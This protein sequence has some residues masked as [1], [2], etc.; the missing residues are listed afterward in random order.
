MVEYETEEQELEA[1]KKWL[2]ENGPSLV[3]GLVLGV[4]GLFG[5]RYY[6]DYK[7]GHSA[8]ASDRYQSVLQQ[9]ATGNVD[10]FT[11]VQAEQLRK[12]YADTP[13]AVLA[14]LA[15]ARNEHDN[16]NDEQALS[17]LDW[18]MKN[19]ATPELEHTARLRTARILL[20]Q[21]KYDEAAVILEKDYPAGFTA[22][23]EELKGDLYIARGDASQARVAYDRAISA[24][25]SPSRWLR[26]KRQDLG[27][28][29][30]GGAEQNDAAAVEPPA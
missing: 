30:M 17:H 24:S 9:V 10:E 16:G 4:G 14:S 20:A 26:L 7:T 21:K 13:Y 28:P 11:A 29:E 15:Q 23:Y 19:A 22:A 25:A 6:L 8:E 27:E 18:A 1:L 12:E 3:I 2:K 5:W